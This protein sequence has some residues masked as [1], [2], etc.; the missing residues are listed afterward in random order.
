MENKIGIALENFL[1]NQ[2]NYNIKVN[3]IRLDNVPSGFMT[4]GEDEQYWSAQYTS[5]H[6]GFLFGSILGTTD[7]IYNNNVCSDNQETEYDYSKIYSLSLSSSTFLDAS[8]NQD[9]ITRTGYI[10]VMD[11]RISMIKLFAIL[12]VV[13]LVLSISL[14]IQFKY[15]KMYK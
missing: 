13:V 6:S 2:C 15:R 4:I 3:W 10:G 12:I 14:E 9:E 5:K 11:S 1:S 8:S 7:F